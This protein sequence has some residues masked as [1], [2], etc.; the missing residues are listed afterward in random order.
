MKKFDAADAAKAA[1]AQLQGAVAGLLPGAAAAGAGGRRLAA[2]AAASG[3]VTPA[4]PLLPL[5]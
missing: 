5:A 1:A 3:Q 2:A 4:R